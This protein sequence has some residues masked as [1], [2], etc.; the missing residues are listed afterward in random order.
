MRYTSLVLS[1]LLAASHVCHGKPLPTPNDPPYSEGFP[2]QVESAIS[3]TSVETTT[4]AEETTYPGL[5]PTDTQD[6]PSKAAETTTATKAV[7]PVTVSA[8]VS[9]A[10]SA[11]GPAATEEHSASSEEEHFD[12]SEEE[13]SVTEGEE[14]HSVTEGEE[15]HSVIE[16]EEEH[17][18]TEEEH[19]PVETSASSTSEEHEAPSDHKD[20]APS[21]DADSDDD[22]ASDDEAPFDHDASSDHSALP[23]HDAPSDE[24][25]Q[26]DNDASSDHDASADHGA[27]SDNENW[28][29]NEAPPADSSPKLH[30]QDHPCGRFDPWTIHSLSRH[31]DDSDT[32]CGWSFIIHTNCP[33]LAPTPCSFTIKSL[34]P[35]VPASRSPKHAKD[36][37]ELCGPYEV[38][39]SWSG[40]FGPGQGFT[41][42][43]VIDAGNKLVA[44]P[45]YR[46]DLFRKE[47]T[48]VPD[49]EVAVYALG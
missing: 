5:Y 38:H 17:F 45:A 31:C 7:E 19:K 36:N 11:E 24:E 9:E 48:T 1:S 27:S 28:S 33:S 8:T 6:F 10:E 23:G 39:S 34:G 35:G 15:E 37:D 18:V 42:L 25:A 44:Y 32:V 13:H 43:S 26:P 4:V 16:G 47:K 21:D 49:V 12:N 2:T 41:T 29:Q 46:D 20:E 40:Q 14:E 22:S 3:T 30:D